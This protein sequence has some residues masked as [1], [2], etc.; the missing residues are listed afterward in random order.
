[1]PDNRQPYQSSGFNFLWWD[2]DMEQTITINDARCVLEMQGDKPVLLAPRHTLPFCICEH[3]FDGDVMQGHLVVL[4]ERSSFQWETAEAS[5]GEYV[6][7]R[8]YWC[9]TRYAIDTPYKHLR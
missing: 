7:I 4:R 1:M 5:E 3:L 9:G 2:D 8:C 6:G